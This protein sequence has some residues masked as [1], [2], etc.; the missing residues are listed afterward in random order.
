MSKDQHTNDTNQQIADALA[1]ETRTVRRHLSQARSLGIFETRSVR[2]G[3]VSRRLITP[4]PALLEA[5]RLA[6][7]ERRSGRTDPVPQG[8]QILSPSREG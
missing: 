2:V 1:C 8:G 3:G 4:G 5:S 6:P 7:P